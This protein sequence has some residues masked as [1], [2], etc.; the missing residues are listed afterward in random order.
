MTAELSRDEGTIEA[1]E[2][3]LDDLDLEAAWLRSWEVRREGGSNGGWVL[4]D[5]PL[6]LNPCM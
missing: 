1:L 3:V 4:G 5:G 2:D 6:L